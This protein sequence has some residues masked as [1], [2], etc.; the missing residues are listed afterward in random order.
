MHHCIEAID[1]KHI[2]MKNPVFSGS[3]WH[4]YKGFL[5]GFTCNIRCSLQLYS[6]RCWTIWEQQC[7]WRFL[8]GIL[9]SRWR[10]L[11]KPIEGT[12]ERIEKIVLATVALHNYLNQTGN[13]H[14]T[15]AGFIDSQDSTGEIIAGQWRKNVTNNLQEIGPVRNSR[16][17]GN[18]LE[19]RETFA[20]YLISKNGF[21][22]WQWYFIRK[23]GREQYFHI[24]IKLYLLLLKRIAEKYAEPCQISK[25]E[26][27]AKTIN[28]LKRLTVF[29][30]KPH[31]RCLTGF[32]IRLCISITS[33]TIS[34]AEYFDVAVKL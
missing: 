7:F 31:L 15:P 11:Q 13:A 3:L 8:F 18:S 22:S 16:Y 27:S 26:M 28:G 17:Q 2:T 23:T 9:V 32:L 21:V 4:N 14:Y 5:H 29:T 20:E 6:N 34:R 24:G 33:K 1:G 10:I 12:P 30:K 25:L 19:V